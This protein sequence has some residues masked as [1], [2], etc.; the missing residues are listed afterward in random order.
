[1]TKDFL[2]F[3]TGLENVHGNPA[4]ERWRDTLPEALAHAFR[5]EAHGRIDEWSALLQRLPPLKTAEVR[6]GS[7]IRV[8]VEPPPGAAELDALHQL[9]LQF[10]P[11]RK[12][13]YDI[14]GIYVDSEWRS[15]L[16]WERLREAIAPLEG[17]LVLDVGCGNGYHLWRM[18]GAGARAVLGL[19]PSLAYVAQ[20]CALRHFISG[21][22][23]YLLPFALEVLP[24]NLQAF[25]T[26]FSMGV[27]YHRRSPFEH[28]QRLQQCLRPAG[29]LILETLVIEGGVDTVLA[30][31]GRYAQMKNVW[32]IP[33]CLTLE[34]WLRQCGFRDIRLLDVTA[35][36]SEEQRATPWSGEVS[37]RDFLDPNDS[38]KTIE[39]YPA[40]QRAIMSAHA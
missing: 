13:P 14:H 37:L 11:W 36:T 24:E 10:K 6:Y 17:R 3:Y 35:T 26:V 27:L 29:E 18:H 19:D 30:P 9:L 28:L 33:S 25:D 4:F 5:P 20:F 2:R 31:E 40:P 21:P 7:A 22:A 12:G 8:R 15:D 1:M 39:G 23:V 32:F 16:K 38:S 34:A